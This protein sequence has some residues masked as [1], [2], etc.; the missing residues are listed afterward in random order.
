M[1]KLLKQGIAFVGISGIGWIMD[2]VIFNLLNLRSSYVAVNNMISSL[3]AVCFVFCVSTRKTF[4]QKD[5]GIPLKVKFVIYILYQ[6]ILILLVSQLLAII[7]AGLYQTFSGSI[8]GNFSAMAAKIIVTPVTM[9]LNFLVMKLLIEILLNISGWNIMSNYKMGYTLIETILV[10]AIVF[11]LGGITITLSIESI[12]DYNLS[13]S[14]CYYEDKFDNAL[15]NLESLCTSAGIEY[16]EA[17]KELNDVYSSEVIG[18]NIT[19]KF[20]DINNDEKIK[21]I[22]LNKEKLMI[23]TI[24]FSNG[25][26]SV[27]NNVLIDKI[28]NFSVKKK[29]KLIYYSIKSKEN[30]VRIRCI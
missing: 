13:L 29:N 8:I 12:N 18:D 10:I 4:V 2:F 20:K 9:C 19:V 22:Y 30:G 17:N 21:I 1:R 27:G 5:G 14:N 7:A 11:I 6:I 28:E 24:G 16:I 23:K 25:I 15:L 26:V 3:V